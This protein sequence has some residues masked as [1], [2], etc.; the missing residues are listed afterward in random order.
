MPIQLTA[1]TLAPDASTPDFAAIYR[2][3]HGFVARTLRHLGVDPG[4]V[5]DAVQDTF[6]VVHR[7]LAEFEGRAAL[8]TWLFEIA[9]RVAGRYRRTAAR[10]APRSCP[11][12][13]QSG[14]PHQDEDLARVEA[15]ELLRVFLDELDRDKSVVFILSE[16]E[17]WRA[18]EIAE[19]LELNLNTVYARLRAARKQLDRVVA[20]V[21][22][23][24]RRPRVRRGADVVAAAI[25][26]VPPDA[27]RPPDLYPW[28]A[29]AVP[30]T[31]K[32]A[33]AATTTAWLT[34]LAVAAIAAFAAQPAAPPTDS[35]AAI[36]VARE[37]PPAPAPRVAAPLASPPAQPT[38]EAP[39]PEAPTPAKPPSSSF[40]AELASLEAARAALLAGDGR[41]A[42]QLLTRHQR[43][44]AAGELAREAAVTRLD[45]L[46]QLGD[47]EAARRE[48]EVFT[49]RWPDVSAAIVTPCR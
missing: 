44:F 33:G 26:A 46:C 40:A 27:L 24:E 12:D 13:D 5:D 3:H 14:D 30:I 36:V 15:A 9:R 17:Q 2:E 35:P 7:R 22:A 25:L 32:L 48:H 6:M 28:P 4:R 29:A 19:A 47:L 11:L 38:P 45:A 18:P 41:R 1:P 10:E 42:L 23:R 34:G 20:R 16:L 39:S 21:Q 43:R 8:R 49:R 31:G 37:S